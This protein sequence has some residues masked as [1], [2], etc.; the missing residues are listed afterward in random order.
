LGL[1]LLN[2][3]LFD[4]SWVDYLSYGRVHSL[5]ELLWCEVPN[6]FIQIHIQ[7]LY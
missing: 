2:Q 3:L 4:S 6:V 7:L 1:E 5:S